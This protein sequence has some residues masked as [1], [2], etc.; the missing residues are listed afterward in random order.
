MRFSPTAPKEKI[1]ILF[2][3][4][5]LLFPGLL[6][7]M[8]LMEPDEARY[9]DIPSMMNRTGDYVTPKLHHVVYL[10]KPPLAYWATAFFFRLLGENEFSSRLFA[11]LS[12]WGCVILAF[13]MGRRLR[14]E[15]TGLY[16]AAILSTFLFH[17]ILAR[18]NILDMPLTFFVA[19]AIWSCYLFLEGGRRGW[20]Y[21]AYFACALAFLTKGLIG[22]VFPFVINGMLLAWERRWRDIPRMISPVGL[23]IFA[24]VSMPWIVMVQEANPDFFRFFFIQEHFLRYTTKMHGREG[25]FLYYLPVMILGTLPWSAFLWKAKQDADVRWRDLFGRSGMGILLIWIACVFFFYSVS[26]SKLIPYAGPMFI[27]AAVLFAR[28]FREAGERKPEISGRPASG[29]S[30]IPI[31]LQ[32]VLFIAVLLAPLALKNMEFGRDLVIMQSD[33]WPALILAPVLLQIMLIFVP[34]LA[35]RRWKRG[36]FAAIYGISALFLG[37]MVFP[38][39]DFLTPYKSAQPLARAIRQS[40][41]ADALVYQYKIALYG[42]DFYNKIRTP[43]VEDFGELGFGIEKLPPEERARYFL[44]AGDFYRLCKEEREVYCVTQYARR[45]DELK[46]E[47]PGGRI[48]WDNDAFFLLKIEAK[49]DR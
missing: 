39:S 37:S 25:A 23:M 7:F 11:G 27:P 16:A 36:W 4:P 21:L 42:I 6:P 5:L 38:M 43:I 10:E 22:L 47:I 48:L 46:K 32:S 1:I 34:D 44:S 30:R 12:A 33:Y 14:D 40:V 19:L 24:A 29:L 13:F 8:P 3:V 15:Q 41:P 45:L 18:I 49:G 2:L 9:S 35:G 31:V 20:L 26:S 28:V 17:F